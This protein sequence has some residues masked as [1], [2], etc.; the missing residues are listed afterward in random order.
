GF[1]FLVEHLTAGRAFLV[2]EES[3][4]M[5]LRGHAPE[6]DGI[7]AALLAAE[8]VA[9]RRRPLPDQVA[10][11]F[12]KVGPLH[13][14]R[15]DYH[16]AAAA[17]ERLVRRLEDVPSH[18]AGRRV[19]R[20]DTTDGRK[21]ILADGSWILFRSSGTESLVRCYGEARS[22]HDLEALMTSAR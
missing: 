16:P 22:A 3:A 10:D 11:L 8:M 2:C 18:L 5:G 21:L 19:V 1:K 12:R 14:R 20:C 4:G 7:L 13:S 17:R 15:I 9:V 6:K